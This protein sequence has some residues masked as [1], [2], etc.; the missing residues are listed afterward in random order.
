LYPI[1]E[2]K[3]G[4]VNKT[5][6]VKAAKVRVLSFSIIKSIDERNC[7]VIA[8]YM[9]NLAASFVKLALSDFIHTD[10]PNTSDTV[11]ANKFKIICLIPFKFW[12]LNDYTSA[13]IT[14]ELL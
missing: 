8:I 13:I 10:F 6:H 7:C 3:I 12:I 9:L 14:N 2:F 4:W 11:T 1:N 5:K